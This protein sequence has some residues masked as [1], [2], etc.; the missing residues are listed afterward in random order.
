MLKKIFKDLLSNS[1]L[2]DS[3]NLSWSSYYDVTFHDIAN[4]YKEA[5]SKIDNNP[6]FKNLKDT[7]SL[8]NKIIN[9]TNDFIDEH[10][11]HTYLIPIIVSISNQSVNKIKSI[12]DVGSGLLPVSL[13]IKKYCNIEIPGSIIET[14]EYTKV[15]NALCDKKN[16]SFMRYFS[17]VSNLDN[18]NFDQ[19]H[20]SIFRLYY[21]YKQGTW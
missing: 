10:N 12:L 3:L 7:N 9:Q 13:Y 14:P 15:L 17:D 1:F 18:K 11:S 6:K 19:N 20:L 8:I 5:Q 16:I 4:N 21:F 2:R